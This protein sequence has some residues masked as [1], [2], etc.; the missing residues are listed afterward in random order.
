MNLL[1]MVASQIATNAMIT[2][3]PMNIREK[4]DWSASFVL[5][6]HQSGRN[7]D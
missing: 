5:N 3:T 2:H 4:M 1:I 6:A 7:E